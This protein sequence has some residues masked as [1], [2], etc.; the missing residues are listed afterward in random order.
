VNQLKVEG[1]AQAAV[2]VSGHSMTN[3]SKLLVENWLYLAGVNHAC[4]CSLAV[5]QEKIC[6]DFF[7]PELQ[8]AI[9]CWSANDD[10]ESLAKKLA[11][12]AFYQHHG[13]D[14]IEVHDEDILQLDELL[15]KRLFNL[16]LAV[17]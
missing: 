2:S 10:A 4:D 5:A 12:Q 7:V 15:A 16:N 13:Y 17:Y 8:L 1:F 11:K 6:A 3:R 9:D 14:Y